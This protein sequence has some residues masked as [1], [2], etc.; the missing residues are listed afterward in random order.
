M[1]Q[2]QP[3]VERGRAE[4]EAGMQAEIGTVLLALALFALKHFLADFVLQPPWMTRGKGQYGHPGG[5]AHAAVHMAGSLPALIVLGAGP[6]A[7]LLLILAEGVVHYHI[8]WTKET[9]TRRFAPDIRRAGYWVLL[10]ADQ[11]L[12]Q[13]TYLAMVALLVVRIG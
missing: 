11:L 12:H 8:D 13:L 6:L 5:F 7:A 9:L 10:G 4:T 2:V 3:V 1:M